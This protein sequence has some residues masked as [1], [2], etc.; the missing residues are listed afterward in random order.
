M[1]LAPAPTPASV[2]GA[3]PPQNLE[4][5]E[6]VLG[7]MML[8]PNAIAA[9]S[10]ILD[11]SDFYRESHA[12]IYR[13]ALQLYGK[14][15]PVDAI[16][17]T[18]ELEQRGELEDVGGR[19]RLHE[20][21]RLVPAT[22]NAGH[23]A[24]IVRETATLRGLILAGGQIAQLGWD[25]EGE[26]TELVARA[27]QLVYE[28]GERRTAGRARPL[29]GRAAR[30]VP[31]DQQPLRVRRRGDRARERL[32]GSRQAHRRLPA[33][34]PRDH[35][36]PPVDGKERLR[37][38]DREP[39]RRR[40][41]DAVRV[42]QPRDVEAGGRAA[43]DLLARQGRRAPHP[44]RQAHARTTGR[45]S[46]RRAA[47]SSRRRSTSTTRRRSACSSSAPARRR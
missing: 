1:S 28:L 9:V 4:A 44:H 20:L 27:E 39:R 29:Q 30:G 32:Q 41:A 15:E 17:L 6:S 46:R 21:A 33:V 11:A 26:P 43:P 13:A 31:D 47:S 23:Y 36:R 18:N 10:E 42:L 8:S 14:N 37:A 25:R 40:A 7:A 22:A 16:T 19:V 24:E 34:E 45:A 3:V 2:P 38:R 35:R 5:E 12:K